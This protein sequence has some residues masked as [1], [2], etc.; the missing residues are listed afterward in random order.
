MKIKQTPFLF[1]IFTLA[2]QLAACGVNT[3]MP[4][5]TATIEPSLTP[6]AVP[7]ST[8][9]QPTPSSTVPVPTL[10][11]YAIPISSPPNG[12]H[13]AYIIDGNLYFQNGDNPP[14]Q[15]THSEED[16]NI[17]FFSENGE[18]IFFLR[19]TNPPF[20]L[21][22]INTDGS[23]E[24]ILVTNKLLRAFDAS[25]NES[26]G[27]H[28]VTIVPGTHFLL[29]S[30]DETQSN[31]RLFWNGDL[32]VVDTETGEI[33][34]LLPRGQIHK[35]Y[36]S[37]DG[38]LIALDTIGTVDV[39]DLGGN[40]IKQNLLTYTP[41]EPSFLAPGIWWMP[42]SKGLII[43][44]P[45][46]T[47][48]EVGYSPAYSVWRYALDD[49]GGV[50]VLLDPFPM[51]VYGAQISPDGNRIIYNNDDQYAFYIG[52]LRAGNTQ[53]YLPKT[54]AFH[55]FWSWNSENEHFVYSTAPGNTLYLGSISESPKRIGQ[56]DFL[57]WIDAN[58]YLYYVDKNVVLG[59]VNGSKEI[60]LV[61]H[62]F[63]NNPA[64]FTFILP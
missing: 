34:R 15:L 36:V 52:D 31:G 20:D 43:L 9:S 21:Y 7:T 38:R 30:T 37:P 4:T 55:D 49:G 2:M 54:F 35:F 32:L 13:M 5:A 28:N 16:W 61:D 3:A 14:L 59:E 47:Y 64:V 22:S 48:F 23:E 42:D 33:K 24:Q 44:L 17:L 10:T 12:L 11:P 51:N 45:V 39:I 56:G 60:I 53:L 18:K 63:F 8:E 58:S 29:F 62:E 40:I 26:A 27:F 25:Y 46:Q 41:S 1:I 50:Q 6:S 57:G 19:G